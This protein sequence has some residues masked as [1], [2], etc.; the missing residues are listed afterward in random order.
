MTEAQWFACTD[1][2]RMPKVAR[3]HITHRKCGLLACAFALDVP[4][5]LN[6]PTARRIV[7]VVRAKYQPAALAE[8]VRTIPTA[9]AAEFLHIFRDPALSPGFQVWQ[10]ADVV[11]DA[12]ALGAIL[13]QVVQYG[14][15]ARRAVNVVGEACL[16]A[17]RDTATQA[18]HAQSDRVRHECNVGLATF[19][20]FREAVLGL[21][22]E[23]DRD[24]L[25]E[26]RWLPN[27]VPARVSSRLRA[28]AVQPR[29]RDAKAKMAGMVRDILGN[30]FRPVVVEPEWRAAN[31]GT[32]ARVAGHIAA[33]GC[34][35]DVPILADALE[36]AGCRDAEL[37]RH[38]RT[39]EHYP[40]CWVVDAVLGVK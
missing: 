5:A 16:G 3:E 28:L 24:R 8:N 38:A 39:G 2:L 34:Y 20:D 32:A 4:G 11:A 37:L 9:L 36:D 35:G 18:V 22:P 40:G 26:G 27:H 17:V 25:R 7:E 33:T 10:R 12:R 13:N 30:P 29:V 1:P 14:R 23:A 19:E 21:L 31:F 6:T 15:P